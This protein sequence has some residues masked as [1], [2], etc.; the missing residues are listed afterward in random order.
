LLSRLVEA[1]ALAAATETLVQQLA[2]S[3]PLSLRA[4]KRVLNGFAPSLTEA[5]RESA[6]RDRIAVMSSQD[7]EEGLRAFLERRPA[8]FRGF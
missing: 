5:Q 7:A 2:A 1:D 3:A 8:S 4:S 6:D